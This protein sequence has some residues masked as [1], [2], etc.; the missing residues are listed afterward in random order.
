[1]SF[2]PDQEKQLK[3]WTT[4][5]PYPIMGILEAMRQVQEWHCRVSPEDEVYIA[6]LFATTTTR[7]HELATFF[8]FFTQK[9]TGRTRIGV[10]RTLSCALAGSKEMARCLE[11][12]LGVKAGQA[13]PDGEFSFEEME[14]LGACEKAPALIVNEELQGAA[15]EQLIDLI[16]KGHGK[17]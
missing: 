15:T 8:P 4:Y 14:C 12:K 16:I 5:F 11:R 1:M 13:T 17:K 3:A 10:C 7:V 9:P 6:A 2:T